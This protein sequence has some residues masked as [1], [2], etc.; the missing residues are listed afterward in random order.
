M[1]FEWKG[2]PVSGWEDKPLSRRRFLGYATIGLSAIIS[3]LVALPLI[4]TLASPI[5]QKK[6]VETKWVELGKTED[7]E[8]GQPTIVQW[9]TSRMDGWVMEAAPRSVYVVKQDGEIFTVFNSRCTHL[10]CAYSWKL[11]G[12]PHQTAYGS[13]MPDKGHFFCP[14]HDGVFD[15][16]GTVIGGP[17]PRPLDTLPV[18]IEGGRLF[19]MYQNFQVGIADKILL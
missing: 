11:K 16:D 5:L 3:G 12:E 10:A 6:K 9:T 7:F 1:S 8:V 13:T 4:G 19:T 17:P 14:C 18:K 2:K 15:I